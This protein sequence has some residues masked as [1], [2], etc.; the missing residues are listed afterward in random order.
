MAKAVAGRRQTTRKVT[1]HLT[2]GE[3]DLVLALVAIV[4]GHR[5]HS[6]AKYARRINEALTDAL[7]YGAA[8]TDA[9]DLLYADEVSFLRYD[10]QD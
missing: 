5:A 8:E 7:G 2:E 6:P 3:A 1:L 10:G 9:Y 4:N